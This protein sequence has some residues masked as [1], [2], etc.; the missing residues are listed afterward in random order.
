VIG[1]TFLYFKNRQPGP[2]VM[3]TQK[4]VKRVVGE[5]DIRNAF[6]NV[7]EDTGPAVVSISTERTH[8]FRGEPFPYGRRENPFHDEFFE[9]FFEDFFR[10]MPEEYEKKQMGLGSGV[11]IDARGYVLTNEHV[12]TGADKISV[13]LPDGRKFEGTLKGSDT[14]SDLAIVKINARDLPVAPLGDSDNVQTGEWVVAIGNP[15]GYIVDSPKPTVTAGVVSALHRSLP[16]KKSGYLNLI[17]TDAAI[18]PGN[19]GGPLCNLAGDVI[20]INVAIFSTTGGYQGVG[21]AIPIN[22]A[23]LVIGDLIKGKSIAY[24]WV[25]V[26]IQD[27]TE[28]LGEYFGISDQKGVLVSKIVKDSPAYRAGLKEG[29]VIVKFDGKKVENSKDIVVNVSRIPIGKEVELIVVREK[30]NVKLAIK[31]GRMPSDE[32]LARLEG[33]PFE[34]GRD[35]VVKKWRGIEVTAI[36]GDL[37]ARLGISDKEGV[38]IVDVERGSPAH[39]A[40]LRAGDVIRRVGNITIKSMEEYSAAIVSAGGDVLIYTD[41]GFTIVK[42]E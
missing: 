40:N 1:V 32:E 8:K 15:F 5:V 33:R 14:R 11:I 26:V 17:Q 10:G 16:S 7:A 13:I 2:K 36:T 34:E 25:G 3:F 6:I 39:Y 29:D 42:D 22:S 12:V 24:G 31:I 21:F 19:S 37:A 35:M 38:I 30:K 27:I 9:R 41:R 18:N 20:G 23:K 28:D 4:G